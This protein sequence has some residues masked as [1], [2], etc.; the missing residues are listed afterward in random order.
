MRPISAS[1]CATGLPAKS[2]RAATSAC[3]TGAHRIDVRRIRKAD[4]S[5]VP[6]GTGGPIAGMWGRALELSF[7]PVPVR[8]PASGAPA[9]CARPRRSPVERQ[10]AFQRS[11]RQHARR[12]RV[13]A[14]PPSEMH[15]GV[16]RLG[17]LV[18]EQGAMTRRRP[19]RHRRRPVP[20]PARCNMPFVRRLPPRPGED[21]RCAS[22]SPVV[23]AARAHER[24]Q[25]RWPCPFR[26]AA[27]RVPRRC[28]RRRWPGSP[29]RVARSVPSAPTQSRRAKQP[30]QPRHGWTTSESRDAAVRSAGSKPPSRNFRSDGG[31]RSPRAP[32]V[33]S[34]RIHLDVA[35]VPPGLDGLGGKRPRA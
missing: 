9:S 26:K 22:R 24:R 19:P 32:M 7:A 33:S 16:R 20:A 31:S 18:V 13:G 11:L 4:G 25:C 12:L 34:V 14:S 29:L 30:L 3:R 8:H 23:R 17:R 27:R 2:V 28:G 1:G 5:M 10:C 35:R 21:A 15:G 6:A